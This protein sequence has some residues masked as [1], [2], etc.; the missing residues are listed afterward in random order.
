MRVLLPLFFSLLGAGLF[1]QRI[2]VQDPIDFIT[3]FQDIYVDDAGTG[4]AVGTCGA[5]VYTED[6]GANWSLID[7]PLTDDNYGAVGCSPAGCAAGV[8]VG[9]TGYL[10]L[11][12]GNGNWTVTQEFG[13]PFGVENI[14]WLTDQVVIADLGQDEY[15]RST[16]GGQS[17]SALTLPVNLRD[18]MSFPTAANG[19]FLGDD[20]KI[21]NTKDQGV[22][23]QETGYTHDTTF[24]K[25]FTFDDDVI[26]FMDAAYDISR[27]LD[28]GQTFTT[29][30]P[31]VNVRTADYFI[32]FSPDTI[33]VATGFNTT[34]LS[35]DAGAT[36]VRPA[37][38]EIAT[39][40][41]GKYHKRGDNVWIL[42]AISAVYY[43]A[44]GFEDFVSQ[45]PGE[46]DARLLAIAF[47]NDEVGY[48]AGNFGR[49]LKTEDGGDSWIPIEVRPNSSGIYYNIEVFSEN[50]VVFF[51]N[52]LSPQVTTD[53]GATFTDWLP[54]S[55]PSEDQQVFHYQRLPGGRQYLL[56]QENALYTDDGTTYTSVPVSLPRTPDAMFFADDNNGW[57]A[58]TRFI[59]RTRDGG[60]SWQ[61]ITLPTTQPLESLYFFDANNGMT[62]TGSRVYLTTDGG[63]TWDTGASPGGYDFRLNA[64]DGG[65]YVA[66]FSTGN[67]GTVNRSYD[68]GQSWEEIAYVCAPFRGGTLTPSGKFFY[69]IGDGGIIVKVD[70]DVV[71][72]VRERTVAEP[73]RVFP[74]PVST[75]LTLEVPPGTRAATVS[76]FSADGRLVQE[77][78][79]APGQ[80]VHRMDVGLLPKG[81]YLVRWSGDNGSVRSARIVRQ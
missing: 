64:D 17:W 19:Y 40:I 55:V 60:L 18:D 62:S 50:E 3:Q 22:S 1:G 67:N 52:G 44:S 79:V 34:Y 26:F 70:I 58:G 38:G 65:I 29:V 45:I 76:V 53:G 21:Y 37:S 49:A 56:G 7:G 46:R 81:M 72:P 78:R 66:S 77:D 32:A 42:G 28:G 20:Q 12:Q 25:I 5:I 6:D 24:R 36:W 61:E 13:T 23:W 39:G 59:Y 54:A 16:D 31:D 27:S 30:T 69:G 51:S 10:A 71:N 2:T 75:L 41:R 33:G 47:A 14:H 15:Y 80:P 57:V 9:G 8:V 4:Y 43:S 48:A 35:A 11:R 74:N 73:L 63:D 68:Q